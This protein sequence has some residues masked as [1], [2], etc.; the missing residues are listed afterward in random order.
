[1]T[2]VVLVAHPVIATRAD[3]GNIFAI[4]V[5][6][7]LHKTRTTDGLCLQ[8]NA[9]A[10]LIAQFAFVFDT[11]VCVRTIFAFATRTTTAAV[12]VTGKR[13]DTEAAFAFLIDGALLS[14]LFSAFLHALCAAKT[15]LLAKITARTIRITGTGRGAFGT[16]VR[17]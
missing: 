13:S 12:G 7:A 5:G 11:E 17:L 14:V 3:G 9:T 6:L 8:T 16:T 2:A 15:V 4:G 10:R 1:M